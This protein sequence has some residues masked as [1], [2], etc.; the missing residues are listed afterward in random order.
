MCYVQVRLHG[1]VYGIKHSLKCQVWFQGLYWGKPVVD[2]ENFLM[3][4]VCAV[5][6][7]FLYPPLPTLDSL[8]VMVSLEKQMGRKIK[9]FPHMQNHRFTKC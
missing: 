8:S 6:G 5:R 3:S 9:S 7:S 1:C 2:S 4:L